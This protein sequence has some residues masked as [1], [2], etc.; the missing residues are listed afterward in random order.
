MNNIPGFSKAQAEYENRLPAD[1][2]VPTEDCSCCEGTGLLPMSNCC[3]SEIHNGVC[4]DC[5][6]T[7]KQAK[8]SECDGT[9]QVEMEP[10]EP[11]YHDILESRREVNDG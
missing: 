2:E 6:Q 5:N 3:E 4:V 11:D 9:G 10:N 8:C 7:C 1:D